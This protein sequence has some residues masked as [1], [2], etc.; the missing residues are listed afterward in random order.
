MTSA[1]MRDPL[2][3]HLIT[4]ENAAFLFIDYQ[5]AQLATVRSM[6]H[7]LL[8]KNAVSTVRTIKTFGVEIVL[9]DRLN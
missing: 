6:D 4:P 8:V 2:A 7:A 1:P 9:T 3:D 5:P